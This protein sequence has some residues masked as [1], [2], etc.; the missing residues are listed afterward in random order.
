MKNKKIK[1]AL[2]LND[3][4]I[5]QSVFWVEK[6]IRNLLD[7]AV[8]YTDN[9]IIIKNIRSCLY[10]ID[11]GCGIDKNYKNHIF[12]DFFQCKTLTRKHSNGVGLGLSIV[13]FAVSLIGGEIKLKSREKCYTI[14]KVC[15]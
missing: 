6:I 15:L 14:F 4:E 10:I 11:N 1:I 5:F 7:N 3:F 12:E 13:D 2:Q 8:K 9:K